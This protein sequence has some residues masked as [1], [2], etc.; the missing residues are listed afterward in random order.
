M[1]RAGV[2]VGENAM[3]GAKAVLQR[4]VPAHHVAV[5]T[6]AT[7]I[8]VKPGWESVAEPI[9]DANTDRREQ[10]RLETELPPALDVFDEF[11]RDLTPPN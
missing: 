10:R 7:S 6:P 8:R 9:E 11:G 4:D 5:G 2:H 3:L 1:V